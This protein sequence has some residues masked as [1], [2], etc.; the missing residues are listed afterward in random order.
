MLKVRDLKSVK[1]ARGGEPVREQDT[2]QYQ[3][4]QIVHSIENWVDACT[5]GRHV[6]KKQKL[7]V[8]QGNGW[9]VSVYYKRQ[10]LKLTTTGSSILT[11]GDSFAEMKDALFLVRDAVIGGKF[12]KQIER[13]NSVKNKA[14]PVKRPNSKRTKS[15]MALQIVGVQ[16]SDRPRAA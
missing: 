11:V 16:E 12:D 8:R 3:H 2:I 13:I 1:G 15:S 14:K 10:K 5:N 4:Q 9:C 6:R 7:A